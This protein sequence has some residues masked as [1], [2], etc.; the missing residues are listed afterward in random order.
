MHFGFFKNWPVNKED[1]MC[2]IIYSVDKGY[3][4][5][6]NSDEIRH[7]VLDI[8]S[9]YGHVIIGWCIFAHDITHWEHPINVQSN[10]TRT[11]G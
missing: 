6:L 8:S 10:A 11:R 3:I 4:W 2:K 5:W 7:V 9:I 1:T